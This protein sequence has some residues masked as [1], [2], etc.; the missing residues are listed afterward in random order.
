MPGPVADLAAVRSD[1]NVRL[2]WTMPRKTTD[3]RAI[4]SDITV[5]VCRRD[6]VGGDCA[7]AGVSLVLAPGADG[8]FSESLPPSTASGPARPLDYFVELFNDSGHSSGLTNRLTTLA[9]GPPSRVSGLTATMD[10]NAVRLQWSPARPG[11]EPGTIIRVYRDP[12]PASHPQEPVPIGTP[13]GPPLIEVSATATSA[14]DTHIRPGEACEY[15]AQR[16][17]Q[18]LVNGRSFELAGELSAVPFKP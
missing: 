3:R 9:G 12:P 2:T 18:V 13:E 11:D 5:R 16:V 8:S 1:N 14:L 17:A 6:S 7:D 10:D 4:R 15:R